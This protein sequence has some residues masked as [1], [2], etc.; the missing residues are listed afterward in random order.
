M[1]KR[2]ADFQKFYY[3]KVALGEACGCAERVIDV[4]EADRKASKKRYLPVLPRKNPLKRLRYTLAVFG[5]TRRK[6]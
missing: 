6:P 2:E 1:R 4:H 3:T 5:L